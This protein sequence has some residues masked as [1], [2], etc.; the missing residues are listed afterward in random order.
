MT[1]LSLIFRSSPAPDLPTRFNLAAHVLEASAARLPDKIALQI[2]RSSGAERWSYARLLAAVQGCATGLLAQGLAPGSRILMRLGNQV[3]F[4][5][6]FLGAIAA[7]LVPVV[8]S[9]QLTEAEITPMAA[10]LNPSLIVGAEGVAL[11]D[12]PAP[13]LTDTDIRA[14]EA[15]APHPFDLGDPNRPAYIIFTSGSSGTPLAVVHAHRAILAREMMHQDWEG[16]TEADRLLHAGALNWTYTLGTGLMDPWRVGATA[17]IPGPGIGVAQLPLLLKRFDTT[18]FAAA[19]G[20]YRQLLRQPMPQMPRLR[21]GLSAGEKLGDETRA[22]WMQ[23]T[24]TPVCEALGMSEVSTF[25]SEHPGLAAPQ[26]AVGYA[27]TGRQIAALG[28]DMQPVPRGTPGQLAVDHDDP[29]LM[30]G[31]L[32]APT[33]TAAHRHGAWYLTGDQVSIAEDGAVTYLGRQDDV[34]N[35]GGFRVS[36]LEVEA[37][38]TRFDG[39]TD[40]AVVEI[41]VGPDSAVIACFYTAAHALPEADLH[42]HAQAHLARYKQPRIFRHLEALPRGAN[43]KLNRRRL[44]QERI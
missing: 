14:M 17:L 19:P 37:A 30:L 25:I 6:L 22:A 12:H 1:Q 4:P 44:R 18:I 33:A 11:P 35:A 15:L 32:D 26:G 16:L 13:R 38:M 36:P 28:E 3:E 23:A 31:Y 40:C 27:Q 8:T 2:L 7:G 20:V 42:A 10:R 43:A 29:G 41:S 5:L 24:G 21:H 39:L 34:M 9:S